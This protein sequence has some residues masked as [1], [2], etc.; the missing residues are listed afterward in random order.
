M[1]SKGNKSKYN[2]KKQLLILPK[3]LQ[4]IV[5]KV[6]PD[7]VHPSLC[8]KSLNRLVENSMISLVDLNDFKEALAVL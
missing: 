5:Q 4:M 6:F 8:S 7:Q 3:D 2:D 1:L